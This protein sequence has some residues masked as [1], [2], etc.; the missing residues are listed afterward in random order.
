MKKEAAY[1][2]GVELA[3]RNAGLVK[4]ANIGD[5]L[6]AAVSLPRSS[7]PFSADYEGRRRKLLAALL[8]ATVGGVAGGVGGAKL[9]D[10]GWGA[11][12][13]VPGAALGG[14]AGLGLEHLLNE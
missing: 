7:N 6:G 13:A 10:S 12:G 4:E 5:A 14:A 9:T 8:G 2:F 1:K 3:L 11:L